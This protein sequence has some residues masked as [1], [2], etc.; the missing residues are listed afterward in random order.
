MIISECEPF[1]PLL[2]ELENLHVAQLCDGLRS[3][4]EYHSACHEDFLHPI[5]FE[6]IVDW[7]QACRAFLHNYLW[8]LFFLQSFPSPPLRVIEFWEQQLAAVEA[9][10]QSLLEGDSA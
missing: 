5:Y 8:H 6:R 4:P 7:L 3:D 9:C 1:D 2:Q 10:Q